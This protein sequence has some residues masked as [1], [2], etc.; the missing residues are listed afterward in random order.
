MGDPAGVMG[1]QLK[2]LQVVLERISVD[3]KKETSEI[4]SNIYEIIDAPNGAKKKE[5]KNKKE[6]KKQRENVGA[7]KRKEVKIKE[8]K[9]EVR[10]KEKRSKEVHKGQSTEG[11]KLKS[12]VVM[13]DCRIGAPLRPPL[14]PAFFPASYEEELREKEEQF[15]AKRRSKK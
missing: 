13:P 8:K 3:S 7:E 5:E 6:S 12:V 11:T 2:T 10:I 9:K 14:R 1:T 15:Y 4:L